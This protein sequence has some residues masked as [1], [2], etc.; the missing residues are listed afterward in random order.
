[1]LA[2]AK[3]L[4]LYTKEESCAFPF[5]VELHVQRAKV[6]NSVIPADH[7]LRSAQYICRL[8]AIIILVLDVFEPR[9]SQKNYSHYV[10]PFR[11]N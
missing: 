7:V 5:T 3:R 2:A 6:L 8:E 1:M 11:G 10:S 9:I 4:S